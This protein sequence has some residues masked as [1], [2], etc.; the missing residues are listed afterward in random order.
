MVGNWLTVAIIAGVPLGV[1][2]GQ[3]FGWRTTFLAVTGLAALSPLGILTRLFQYAPGVRASLAKPL[4]LASRG[5][6]QSLDEFLGHLSRQRIGCRRGRSGHCQWHSSSAARLDR[7]QPDGAAVSTAQPQRIR[8]RLIKKGDRQ[9]PDPQPH[10]R[11]KEI[12]ETHSLFAA[13]H[14]PAIQRRAR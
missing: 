3:S 14:Q 10:N 5:A 4:E 12:N 13:S 8:P 11:K 2:V 7:F 9:S 1:L 6:G